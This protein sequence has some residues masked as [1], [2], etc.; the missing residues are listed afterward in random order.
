MLT[1]S[2]MTILY[3][4]DVCIQSQRLR[5]ALGLLYDA[6]YLPNL[7]DL[8][9]GCGDIFWNSMSHAHVAARVKASD[10]VLG[11]E[12]IIRRV[13]PPE[14]PNP[15]LFLPDFISIVRAARA[16]QDGRDER[17]VAA[18]KEEYAVSDQFLL[19][20]AQIEHK[21]Q[22]SLRRMDIDQGSF[23]DQAMM[24]IL[25]FFVHHWNDTLGPRFFVDSK[26]FS[27]PLA[28]EDMTIL[29]H[30]EVLYYFLPD[31]GDIDDSDILELRERTQEERLG[32]IGH[33]LE[34]VGQIPEYRNTTSMP[35]LRRF[36]R[37]KI[38]TQVVPAFVQYLK[39]L[40]AQKQ[41]KRVK[42]VSDIVDAF[43]VKGSIVEPRYWVNMLRSLLGSVRTS[44][45]TD[46]QRASI[47]E[48]FMAYVAKLLEESQRSRNPWSET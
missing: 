6:I 44:K 2:R 3:C 8:Y 48:D 13:Q 22:G 24:T 1:P 27:T 19:F 23:F 20:V 41:E 17:I 11:Q 7:T 34:L 39:R 47:S 35:E 37:D 43:A 40:R 16:F 28:V 36:L 18:A 33:V 14:E 21:V 38:A 32:Y 30:D 29:L 25:E 42:T 45:T 31:V 26:I 5:A 12:G 15:Q 9:S 4:S 46:V 10:G